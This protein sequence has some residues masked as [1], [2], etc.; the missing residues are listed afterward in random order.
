[1]S[2]TAVEA[3]LSEKVWTNLG[4]IA[5]RTNLSKF[6]CKKFLHLMEDDDTV[7]RSNDPDGRVIYKLARKG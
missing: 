7:V 6:Q 2:R 5:E 3:A 4:T 1:M